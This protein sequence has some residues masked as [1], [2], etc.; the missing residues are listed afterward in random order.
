[1][2]LVSAGGAN[3]AFHGRKHGFERAGSDSQAA[4]ARDDIDAVVVATRHDS[5]ARLTTAALD[6]GHHVFC[7][8]PLCLTTD[9]LAQ[10]EAAHD[11]AVGAI[12]MVGFN[13]RFAPHT[14]TMR[15]LLAGIA[16]PK[17]FVMTVNAGAIPAG[18]W[19]QD[20]ESGG[21]RII[22]E[23]CHF[24]DLL[25]HLANA[26]IVQ[27]HAMRM[28]SHPALEV[29]GDKATITLRFADGSIG[30]VHYLANGHRALAKERLE[31]FAAGRALQ[32]DNW[33]SLVGYGWA[34]FT[35]QKLR[36]QDKGTDA[37]AAAFIVAVQAG[38]PSPI[39]WEETREIAA[40][41]IQA[42]EQ[43]R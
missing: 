17:A 2:E 7:E 34:G 10:I 20:A 32:L 37:C 22:G 40:R 3:A 41:S 30:T 6:A 33:V 28:G 12:V 1:M 21:G 27:I 9:E 31:V 39:A 4:I 18:H 14:L 26:P 36:R 5:H 42:A 25:R 16:E 19:T 8:K 35:R 43:M 13:R 11:D 23:A 38:G 15:S 29:A 24:I